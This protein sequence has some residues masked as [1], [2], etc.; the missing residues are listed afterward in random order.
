MLCCAPL[1]ELVPSHD[2]RKPILSGSDSNLQGFGAAVRDLG[3][4]LA[5]DT[6]R[7]RADG[8]DSS[9][10]VSTDNVSMATSPS[11]DADSVSAEGEPH[12]VK[13]RKIHPEDATPDNVRFVP[14]VCCLFFCLDFA[15]ETVTP[16]LRKSLANRNLKCYDS[17]NQNVGRAEHVL[18][19]LC[20]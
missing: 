10:E 1:Q 2:N 4:D 16:L 15:H 3:T 8:D 18:R 19:L 11:D 17:K 9:R 14:L 5:D 20:D 7:G 12:V 6:G 13:M